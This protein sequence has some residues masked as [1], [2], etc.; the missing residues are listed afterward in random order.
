MQNVQGFFG[1]IEDD[2]ICAAPG[3]KLALR[4]MQIV[5]YVVVEI[6]NRG[7]AGRIVG[8]PRIQVI[9]EGGLSET[10]FS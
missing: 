7:Q 3:V 2:S 8:T 10:T 5:Q 6:C 1:C 4:R 9:R